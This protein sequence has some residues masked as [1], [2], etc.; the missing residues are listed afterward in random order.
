[1]RYGINCD[2]SFKYFLDNDGL[3]VAN[4]GLENFRSTASLV[5]AFNSQIGSLSITDF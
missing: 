3:E 4:M 2:T 5:L 1:M